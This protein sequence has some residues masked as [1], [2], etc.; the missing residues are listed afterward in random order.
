MALTDEEVA[1][2]ELIEDALNKV[3]I[4]LNK[5]ISKL[6]FRQLMLAREQEISD[7]TARI[8]AVEAQQET[9]INLLNTIRVS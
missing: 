8:D 9:I 3:L 1:R 5:T 4:K 6:Q 2:I 7:L